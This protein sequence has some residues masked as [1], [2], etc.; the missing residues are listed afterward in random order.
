MGGGGSRRNRKYDHIPSKVDTNLINLRKY[1]SLTSLDTLKSSEQTQSDI[2]GAKRTS[3][4]DNLSTVNKYSSVGDLSSVGSH[5]DSLSTRTSKRTS[6][7]D[8]LSTVVK[9]SSVDRLSSVTP[10]STRTQ[11]A[12]ARAKRTS[13]VDEAFSTKRNSLVDEAF[14]TK[15]NLLVDEG[16]STVGSHHHRRASSA[17][18]TENRFVKPITSTYSSSTT[19]L[20]TDSSTSTN[21]N[22]NTVSQTSTLSLTNTPAHTNTPLPSSPPS[23]E[24]FNFYGAQYT[25]ERL[26]KDKQRVETGHL[27]QFGVGR[28]LSIRN[29]GDTKSS[30]GGLGI[31]GGLGLSS[32]GLGTNKM[33]PGEDSMTVELANIRASYE[34]MANKLRANPLYTKIQISNPMNAD[35][36]KS[37]RPVVTTTVA[38]GLGSRPLYS[39]SGSET[40]YKRSG[41]RPS[42]YSGTSSVSLTEEYLKDVNN[43]ITAYLGSEKSSTHVFN[44]VSHKPPEPHNSNNNNNNSNNSSSSNNN[45]NTSSSN[46]TNNSN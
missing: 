34:E 13:S 32:G 41:P 2:V 44:P 36:I 26:K 37:P 14:S 28:A 1:T 38:M 17:S 25:R 23:T 33:K 46:N 31:S 27:S 10:L 19:D 21:L 24:K 35:T 39:R 4:V 30:L 18:V 22:T 12:I 42:S 40:S 29:L 7:M 6:S 5:A 3:S 16:S 9:S 8:N 15:R 11:S 45:S 43:S 20:R